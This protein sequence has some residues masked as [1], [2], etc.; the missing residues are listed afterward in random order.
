MCQL[1][2]GHLHGLLSADGTVATFISGFKT[3]LSRQLSEADVY[4]CFD[5][6]HDYSTKSSTR[7]ARATN[8]RV[9]YLTLTTPLPA[10][11]T[12]LKNYLH[13]QGKAERAYL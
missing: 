13:Q 5:R 6:Y 7:S 4:L 11:D 12:V 10:R 2:F 3:W 8:S 1:L 9:H